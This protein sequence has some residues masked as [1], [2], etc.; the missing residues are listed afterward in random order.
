MCL[1]DADARVLA[2]SR[3]TL[4]GVI[5]QHPAGKNGFG[6]DPLLYL[7]DERRTSAQLTPAEKNARSHRG[8]AARALAEA[9]RTISAGNRPPDT[10]YAR[11]T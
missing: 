3:G 8:S 1:A 5:A 6:Y 10:P 9:L 2:E 11:S 4:E 7:P